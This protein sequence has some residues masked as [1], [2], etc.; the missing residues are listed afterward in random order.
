MIAALALAGGLGCGASSDGGEA[1]EGDLRIR[2]WAL[3]PDAHRTE[4]VAASRADDFPTRWAVFEAWR[5]ADEAGIELPADLERELARAWAANVAERAPHP[6]VLA[7][8]LERSVLAIDPVRH[9][10]HPL[11]AVRVAALERIGRELD[12]GARDGSAELEERLLERGADASR[13]VA[14]TAEDVLAQ[15]GSRRW[16]RTLDGLGAIARACLALERHGLGRRELESWRAWVAHDA[17]LPGRTRARGRALVEALALRL[18]GEGDR[19]AIVVDPPDWSADV[20]AFLR[21]AATRGGAE[22][23]REALATLARRG[24]GERRRETWLELAL[25]AADP[26]VCLEAARAVDFDEPLSIELLQAIR[27]SP[28]EFDASVLGPW[29]EHSSSEVRGLA[30]QVLADR[31]VASGDE[32]AGEELARA[33]ELPGVQRIA[34]RALASAPDPTPWID[35]LHATWSRASEEERPSWLATFPRGVEWTAFRDDW[36][37]LGDE[38]REWRASVAELCAPLSGDERVRDTLERW[39]DEEVAALSA[40]LAAGDEDPAIGRTKVI[41][42]ALGDVAPGGA[43]AALARATDALARR[44]EECGKSFVARLGRSARGRAVVRRVFDD[45]STLSRVR[46]EAALMLVPHDEPEAVELLRT[47]FATCDGELRN[48]ILEAFARCDDRA[49]LDFLTQVATA[50]ELGVETRVAATTMLARRPDA[51]RA[52]ERLDRVLA[53]APD[54]DTARAAIAALGRSSHEPARADLLA[55]LAHVDHGTPLDE[56]QRRWF[57]AAGGLD[58]ALEIG[59]LRDVLLTALASRPCHEPELPGALLRGPLGVARADLDDRMRDHAGPRV[60]FRWRGELDL[61][62]ALAEAGR[63]G[64]ALDE[65]ARWWTVDGRFLDALAEVAAREPDASR[66]LTRAALVA[67]AGEPPTSSGR[68]VRFD[69]RT[70]LIALAEAAGAWSTVERLLIALER[71]WRRRALSSAGERRWLGRFD[72]RSGVDPGARLRAAIEQV[73]ARAALAADDLERSAEHVERAERLLGSSRAAH[74][75]QARLTDELRSR[76]AR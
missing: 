11:T 3:Q 71:D 49:S 47:R 73:R 70:R 58:V 22:L 1:L 67:L 75:E 46:L 9:L 33:L 37:A 56:R 19:T 72:A 18:T 55:L 41:G 27:S 20:H 23:A 36:L 13:E 50:S 17:P 40:A 4:L 38:R 52:W 10:A 68:K 2:G 32:R 42:L 6:N 29:L 25:A 21:R 51:A 43:V 44:D 64:A 16:L 65:H 48:R 8:A 76:T 59:E 15:L 69:A 12:S 57:A 31:V 60:E 66:R 7:L 53:A 24:A 5:R 74:A 26:G 45:P 28:F 30:A 14:R 62:R 54:V 35:D 39:L 61:G 63:L 34:F